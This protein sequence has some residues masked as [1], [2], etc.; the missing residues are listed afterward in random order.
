MAGRRRRFHEAELRSGTLVE[1]RESGAGEKVVI[2][3]LSYLCVV[4]NSFNKMI[5]KIL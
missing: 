3:W 2:F 1:G 4:E 5:G